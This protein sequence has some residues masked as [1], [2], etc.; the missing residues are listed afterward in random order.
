[1][2]DTNTMDD[3]PDRV[4]VLVVGGGPTGLA[5]AVALAGHD[6]EVLV[7]EA[8]TVP[9]LLPRSRSLDIRTM[10]VLRRHGVA[11]DILAAVGEARRTGAAFAFAPCLAAL[12]RR[13][14][15]A[16][17]WFAAPRHS[18]VTGVVCPQDVVEQVLR[19]HAPVGA[20]RQGA[21]LVGLEQHRDG[22]DVHLQ[23]HEGGHRTVRAGF[24]VGADGAESRVRRLL[25]PEAGSASPA[26]WMV[27][28]LVEADLSGCVG[29]HVCNAYFLEPTDGP[30][31]ILHPTLDHTRWVLNLLY[32]ASRGFGSAPEN[33]DY[34][35]IRAVLGTNTQ[36]LR[37][38]ER[39]ATAVRP[40]VEDRWLYG[41]VLLAGDA[42]HQ[43][44]PLSGAGMNLGIG[45]AD[46]LAWKLAAVLHD[47]ANTAL[48]RTY[49]AERRTVARR[50][51]LEDLVNVDCALTDTGWHG[52]RER[53]ADRM[54]KDG[55]VLGAGYDNGAFVSERST[56]P[57]QNS[58]REYRPDAAPGHRAPH[59][60]IRCGAQVRSLLDEFGPE[61]V[62]LSA[63]PAWGGAAVAASQRCGVPLRFRVVPRG[64]DGPTDPTPPAWRQLYGVGSRGAVLIRP[65]GYVA[66]RHRGPDDGDPS[67]DNAAR[68]HLLADAV[69]WC[70]SLDSRAAP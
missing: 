26:A 35:D 48:L 63:D 54:S 14:R 50:F 16:Q 66:W 39:Q 42:V 6:V 53:H 1:M 60:E 38:L 25:A 69:R 44:S 58:Y 15:L 11:D 31:A 56:S 68:A 34:Q 55:L 19:W 7:A 51:L 52:W 21:H 59:V 18:P 46:N 36:G 47:G 13:D 27:S 28:L 22:V 5:T 9:P 61:A 3:I 29:A 8:R 45:D 23:L 30:R 40:H 33:V 32:P 67:P 57:D 70:W 43:L 10:E 37:I 24:V 2:N 65:D 41:R 49:E 4:E 20:L 62:L 17:G 12:G 64:S